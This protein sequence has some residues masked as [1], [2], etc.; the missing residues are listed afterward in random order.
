MMWVKM[1]VFKHTHKALEI[2][3]SYTNVLFLGY[4][5]SVISFI[6]LT[7]F[8][9]NIKPFPFDLE[10]LDTAFSVSSC[11]RVAVS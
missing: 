7:Y 1:Q 5:S 2:Q 9:H 8:I 6:M 10:R 3:Y 11:E 4:V